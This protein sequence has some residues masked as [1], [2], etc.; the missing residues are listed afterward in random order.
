MLA[1]ISLSLLLTTTAVPLREVEGRV[2]SR[3][4]PEFAFVSAVDQSAGE[5][6]VM[7]V[8]AV[9]I[10]VPVPGPKGDVRNV[11]RTELRTIVKRKEG[12]A[13]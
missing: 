2:P 8:R 10:T 7:Q 11:F 5:V 9:T 3:P 13:R 12:E 4:Q 6:T 1:P